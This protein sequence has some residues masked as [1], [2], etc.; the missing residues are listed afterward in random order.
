MRA[1]DAEK[2]VM[3]T[4]P[5]LASMTLSGFQIAMDRCGIVRSGKAAQIC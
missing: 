5:S 2:S 1:R 3:S 4:R